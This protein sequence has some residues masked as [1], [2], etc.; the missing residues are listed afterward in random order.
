MTSATHQMTFRLFRFDVIQFVLSLSLLLLLLI[1]R[2]G[3]LVSQIRLADGSRA[4]LVD[5]HWGTKHR[6]VVDPLHLDLVSKAIPFLE[7]DSPLAGYL[8]AST[9]HESLVLW[10]KT[11]GHAPNKPLC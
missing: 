5:Y 1:R 4:H 8:D 3:F 6:Y 7:V 2:S 11:F 9:H 10:T